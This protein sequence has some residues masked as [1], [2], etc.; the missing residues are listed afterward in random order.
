MP[1][2]GG[3]CCGI[4]PRLSI[5][6]KALCSL[7]EETS[8]GGKQ[9]CCPVPQI[10]WPLPRPC[11]E[12]RAQLSHSAGLSPNNQGGKSR[13]LYPE[14]GIIM[15][16]TAGAVSEQNWAMLSQGG[17]ENKARSSQRSLPR[18]R[19]VLITLIMSS[20]PSL[21]CLRTGRASTS[22]REPGFRSKPLPWWA[23]CLLAQSTE[24]R[25]LS[26]H[27]LPALGTLS[28]AMGTPK[29]KSCCFCSRPELGAYF[30]HLGCDHREPRAQYMVTDRRRPENKSRLKTP[31]WFVLIKKHGFGAFSPPSASESSGC[32]WL[33]V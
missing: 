17:T 6:N 9:L 13:M 27:C 29:K 23:V 31:S 22:R 21:T 26:Q 25:R 30:L 11:H 24:T 8:A 18:M 5:D 32:L 19:L 14:A 16:V 7:C 1:P 10:S 15:P 20:S 2:A 12:V 33:T 3:S 4:Q 28:R